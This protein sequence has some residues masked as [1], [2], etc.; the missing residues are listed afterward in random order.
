[1][2]E[3]E[4]IYEIHGVVTGREGRLLRGA[5][6]VIWWQH[7][8][9]RTNLAATETSEHG[10]YD[11]QYRVPET[12]APPKL[13]LVEALSEYLDAPLYSPLTQAEPK[14]EINLRYEPH[15]QSEWA[16]LVRAIDPLLEGV[17][18]SELVENS[19]H[20][21]IT[22]LAREVG[23]DTE[24]IMRV[25]VS[26]RLDAAFHVPAPAF[27]AFLRQHIPAALPS[28]L[29]DASQD[30]TLIDSLVHR[31]GSLIFGLSEATQTQTLTAA[32]ALN[33]IGAQFTTQIQQIVA[34][35]QA[36][37]TTDLLNQPYLVGN[38]SL[39]QLLV[40]AQLPEDK[41][42]SFAQALATN[43]LSMRNFWRTL[44]DGQHG[45]TAAEASSIER[46]LSI[47]AFVKNHVPLVQVL[48]QGFTSG[49]YASLADLAKLE[50]QFW[51]DLLNRVGA[52]ANIEGTPTTSPAE[53]FARVV[54][55]LQ[56]P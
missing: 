31:I 48:M 15:D 44:G 47:G 30:F 33:V 56:I 35:L 24:T 37:R 18:L 13:L 29:L 1:M 2:A 23:N 9:E 40:V 45:F 17:K 4:K 26:A 21:D 54:S 5:R 52:P 10:R 53:V 50:Q 39:G 7:I 55:E 3:S 46:T 12:L 42:Q 51:I 25:A 32:V 36:Q 8:R 20:Q 34:Q 11:I 22:F 27:Y 41:Q 16:T 43:T 28:P 6:V 19:T 14:L 38:A 49:T